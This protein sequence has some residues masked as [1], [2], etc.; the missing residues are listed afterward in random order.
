MDI[1]QLHN[2][3]TKQFLCFSKTHGSL[4]RIDLTVGSSTMLPFVSAVTYRPRSMSDH[5]PLIL[6]L[7]VSPPVT[8]C[9]APWK[10]NAFWLKLFHS[11]EGIY[12]QYSEILLP[13]LLRVFN[14]SLEQGALPPSMSKANIILLLK[15]GKMRVTPDLTDRSC[16]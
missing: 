2:P 3:Y 11:L 14:A 10:F 8:L 4:Y 7:T 15:A 16:F 9:K 5:S 1:W 6:H 12:K 13:R